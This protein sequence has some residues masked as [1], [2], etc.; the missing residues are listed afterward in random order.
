MNHEKESL[1]IYTNY[2]YPEPA[3]IA[4]LCRDLCEGLK[5][6]YTVTVICAVPCYT[7]KVEPQYLTRSYFFEE[8]DD[9]KVIRVKVPPFNKASKISRVKNI[10]AY[11]FRSIMATFKSARA[12]VIIAESQPPVLGGLL[13]VIGKVI[14]A[15]RG[16]KSRLYY[17]IQDYNPEQIMAVNYNKSNLILSAMMFFDKYSCRVAEKVIVVGRDMIETMSKRFTLRNGEISKT[18]PNVVCINNWM[19]DKEVYPL[20]GSDPG[21][22][23][24]KRRYGLE[25]KFVIM[26]SGNIGLFYD[27]LNL[28]KVIERFKEREDIIFPF[29]GDGVLKKQLEEYVDTHGM[30]NVVFIPYQDKAELAFSLN[31]ADVHWIVNARGI[32]GVS[33][34]S[35]LYGILSA[36]KP[37][38]AVLEEGTD[39]R[40]IIESARCGYA[41]SP[42]D[43]DGVERLI[44][45][46]FNCK[47]EELEDMGNNGYAYLKRYLTKERAIQRYKEELR[48]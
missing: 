24:F 12:D 6:E 42:Q 3:S 46:F 39:A 31:A 44:E 21:V 22:L 9:I 37:A 28:I 45:R 5:D 4:M 33:C 29:V 1:T 7:G 38:L 32:K 13:G 14:N 47:R 25:G 11:F 17:V 35:K 27:L 36:S 19:D 40:M 8:Y 34:P 15:L 43:Y 18:L 23:A 10:V 2:Y 20:P 48:G 26:Y 16:E 30:K 41:A